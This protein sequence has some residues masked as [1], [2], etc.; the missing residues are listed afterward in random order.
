MTS[1]RGRLITLLGLP[2]FLGGSLLS[3][4]VPVTSASS[5]GPHLQLTPDN[6]TQWA[7]PYDV[8]IHREVIAKN[9]GTALGIWSMRVSTDTNGDVICMPQPGYLYLSPGETERIECG[10]DVGLI[11]PDSR[12][13]QPGQ[14]HAIAITLT[15]YTG[16]ITG[17]APSGPPVAT[18]ILSNAVTGGW[19]A[20]GI[21]PSGPGQP[22]YDHDAAIAVKV[23]DGSAN[24]VA[25]AQI[26]ISNEET[27]WDT[28]TT[29][30]ST[31]SATIPVQSHK[32][33][34]LGDWQ[35]FN[36]VISAPGYADAHVLV[37]PQAG[38]TV[39][40]TVVLHKPTV[41]ASYKMVLDYDTGMPPARSSVSA[42]GRYLVT[43]PYLDQ[44]LP[45]SYVEANAAVDFFDLQTATHLWRFPLGSTI[46]N[47]DIS[48]D[49]Q[50]VAALYQ[51]K[52]TGQSAKDSII[53]L[54]HEGNVV[55]KH[56]VTSATAVPVAWAGLPTTAPLIGGVYTVKFS[57]DGK[58]LAYGTFNG[59]VVVLDTNS[60]A[61]LKQAFVREQ[62][63]DIAWSPDGSRLYASAGDNNV[64]AIDTATG[65]ILWQTDVGGWSLFWS[66]S[67]DYALV[68]AKGGY[69]IT[70]LNL[71]DGHILWQYPV[72]DTSFALGISSDQTRFLSVNDTGAAP[73]VAVFDVHGNVVWSTGNNA[74]SAAWSGDGKYAL[75]QENPVA[76]PNGGGFDYQMISG[77][78][79]FTR[80]GDLIWSTP[81]D[82][83]NGPWD[84]GEAGVTYLSQ[85]ATTIVVGDNANGHV[86]IYKGTLT[87]LAAPASPSASVPALTPTP[88]PSSSTNPLTTNV[89]QKTNP[90]FLVVGIPL[91][92]VLIVIVG[93]VGLRH[94]RSTRRPRRLP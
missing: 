88:M 58:S 71:A 51:G 41:A 39:P 49:G 86:Y 93:V 7:L 64:Y 28:A 77:I 52:V 89:D 35:Q 31:G 94:R 44:P 38:Q 30:D 85:D 63:R 78:D 69:A 43:A 10:A 54:D 23:V 33:P 81:I 59:L 21:P 90:L 82:T 70:L 55:W 26:Q 12:N 1:R 9:T 37:A 84:H 75:V 36:L 57:P 62:V 16:A 66:I 3:A 61:V 68:S 56:Q 29:A 11:A 22:T 42:D 79:L 45:D 27:R 19:P 46:L 91:M 73:G 50:Y 15:F 65:A 2:L 74:V 6:N 32:R 4:A 67:K 18:V 92:V 76:I 47:V 83:P 17:N 60:Q 5:G 53:L 25:G 34:F 80:D 48:P 20:Q 72:L 14:T 13:W 8:A 24:F 87:N 40:L